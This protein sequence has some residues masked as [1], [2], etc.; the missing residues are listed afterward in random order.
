MIESEAQDFVNRFAAAWATRDSNAFIAIWHADGR[1]HSPFN[2]RIVE[3]R[4]LGKLN[5]LL[6]AQVPHLT[7][8]LLS[9]TWRGD[10]VVVEW[11]NSN[12]Y[13]DR[14]LRWRG[15]DKFT[16]RDGRVVEEVVYV[17]TAPMQAMR[18]GQ[19]VVPLVQLADSLI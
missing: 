4:E 13:G 10:V 8:T 12:R 7:W 18:A 1:L 6:S 9:W 5:E 3:G 15:V 14:T 2:S 17:D 16:L 19:P 11:E